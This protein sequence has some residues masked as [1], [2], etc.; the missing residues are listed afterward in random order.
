[1]HSKTN[2]ISIIKGENGNMHETTYKVSYHTARCSEA[3]TTPDNFIIP[4]VKDRFMYA[5]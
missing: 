3:H 2:L 4:C 5:W 1:M